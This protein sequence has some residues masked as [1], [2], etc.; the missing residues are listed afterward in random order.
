M[1][2][3]R[4][5]L[6]RVARRELSAVEAAVLLRTLPP[7]AAPGRAESPPPRLAHASADVGFA[8]DD[9][10]ARRAGP[11]TDLLTDLRRMLAA[12]LKL[13][14]EQIDFDRPLSDYGLT[15]IT[16]TTLLQAIN[17]AFD[18]KLAPTVI[19]EFSTL[20]A[21]A[22]HLEGVGV[23]CRAGSPPPAVVQP[24]AGVA[25]IS[26]DR[27]TSHRDV[28]RA[29]SPSNPTPHA[30]G[31]IEA[32]LA[33]LWADAER[34]VTGK[35]GVSPVPNEPANAGETPSLA[36]EAATPR[37]SPAATKDR[38]APLK[39]A[40]IGMAGVMPQCDDLDAFWDALIAGRDLIT[41]APRERWDWTKFT[42]APAPG[43]R[44]GG[45]IRDPDKFD[46]TFFGVSPL[47]AKLMDPQQR[48]FLQTVWHTLENAGYRP[49]DLAGSKTAVFVGVSTSDYFEAMREA[50]A[51]IDAHTSTGFAHCL[52][53]NRVS[54]LFDWHGPSQI[55]DTACSSSLIA[56]HRAAQAIA[57]GDCST[58]LVGGVNL[59]LTPT[60]FLSFAKA[61]MLSPDGRCQ[62]FDRRANGYVRGEG[63]GAVLLK[64]LEQAEADGD[65]IHAVILAT[66]ENHGG[67]A[68]SLTAPN[69]AVQA[70]LLVQA[71]RCAGI[72][73]RTVGYVE[74]HGTGTALG[75]PI[76]FSGLQRA[77]AQLEREQ[78]ESGR[79]ALPRC[80]LGS[81]KT[82]I[83]HL[84]SAAG[85][86][87]LVKVA[88]ALQHGRIPPNLH[89]RD[90][91]PHLGFDG[92]RF[93]V[94][95]T[96]QPW[97][98]TLSDGGSV[99]CVRRAGVSSFGFGGAYAHAVLE[100]HVS[101]DD[102]AKLRPA[103]SPDFVL[104]SAPTAE[105]L[106]VLLDRWAVQCC[107]WRRAGS[108][109]ALHDLAATSRAGRVA[110]RC[111]VAL[112][113]ASLDELESLLA[114]A[115][116]GGSDS[117]ILR[118]VAGDTGPASGFVATLAATPD[119]GD[120][121]ALVRRW[122]AGEAIAWAMA[123]ARRVP[124]PLY[125]FEKWRHWFAPEN[126]SLRARNSVVD[127]TYSNLVPAADQP[128][129]HR[130]A[131]LLA[132]EPRW[133]RSPLEH[134]AVG[135]RMVALLGTPDVIAAFRS[136]APVLAQHG[137]HVRFVTCGEVFH[138]ANG[139]GMTLDA[140]SVATLGAG[141]RQLRR[142]GCGHILLASE[143]LLPA[144][145]PQP[146]RGG[147]FKER[148]AAA[149]RLALRVTQAAVQ[150][151]AADP[152]L[153]LAYACH[154]STSIDSA[155]EEAVAALFASAYQERGD[156]VAHMIRLAGSDLSPTFALEAAVAEL[157]SD[158]DEPGEV[159]YVDGVRAVR[160]LVERLPDDGS[161]VPMQRGATYVIAGG[162]GELGMRFAAWVASERA[163]TVIVLGRRPA[164]AEITARLA[165]FP[166]GA[167][168]IIYQQADITDESAVRTVVATI[169]QSHGPIRGVFHLA[170]TVEAGT[171]LAKDEPTF[172][173]VTAAKVEGSI[174]LDAAT[175]DQPL[176]FFALFSSIAGDWGLG[177]AADYAYAC[178][179]QNAFAEVRQNWVARGL[180]SGR[181]IALGW[182]QWRYDAHSHADRDA[183]LE[184]RGFE[185]LDA[186][187]GF[188]WLAKSANVTRTQS[189]F[190]LGDSALLRPMLTAAGRK[191]ALT[192]TAKLKTD[193][194]SGDATES[195]DDRAVRELLAE[196]SEVDL[197]RLYSAEFGDATASTA[198]SHEAR[199]TDSHPAAAP[200][201]DELRA[202]IR[203]LLGLVLQHAP[204]S[205]GGTVAFERLGMDSIL[206]VR[207][208]QRLEN[209]LGITIPPRWLIENS[210]VDT[211]AQK[212]RSAWPPGL[213]PVRR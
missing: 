70:A 158:A 56:L 210:T 58:A 62:T 65:H 188:S 15:S 206:G 178:R 95:T 125:P 165:A 101:Q 160:Q 142:D 47:E 21:F 89:F 39:L 59:L 161:G 20:R 83:G 128:R 68:T 174:A 138:D 114:I 14:P 191:R 88:L 149:V 52:L 82:N 66:A 170:R 10:S 202:T 109:P 110:H 49:A 120:R 186:E 200:T 36:P 108:A 12:A 134:R 87:G 91:N 130:P 141:L 124:L 69:P 41:E 6:A 73:P 168:R 3:V 181:T 213:S 92:T 79:G 31:D 123:G 119:A 44:Y 96:V 46:A 97:P 48:L 94:P 129:H 199:S 121:E 27:S 34:A 4:D 1:S 30:A 8:S 198:T 45:F 71:Y 211:L 180:R 136:A 207:V 104:L 156:L 57:A 5:I 137:I 102:D 201:S 22:K 154:A 143:S 100:Q 78:A 11:A 144:F 169:V 117:R 107:R 126:V 33:A 184:A 172:D 37:F 194:A 25:Q 157:A 116:Q 111:R 151:C 190:V 152:G 176:D 53:A 167:G 105:Q 85:I 159:Q 203:K 72:D 19:F 26:A 133:I 182:P 84:E 80:W 139:A 163:S 61:G 35:A 42:D 185:L 118:G 153:R 29:R 145:A 38:G 74:T 140:R 28:Q 147:I 208:V 81:V 67:R 150:E 132:Y 148:A 7:E 192:A 63:V 50:G 177:G 173:R 146:S 183:F 18:T 76:E 205:I 212:I 16:V 51:E 13:A 197:D 131:E 166:T 86:A 9:P 75:D 77:F 171:L 209:E 24:R 103:N 60:M 175:A 127:G 106:I 115:G 204:E 54:F 17:D 122:C 98:G 164:G 187:R 2:T 113:V 193:H 155:R 40:I 43:A 195:A 112:R 64:S 189:A 23:S 99:S 55:V 90:A 32:E 196:M 179:F 93:A 162:L 135:S